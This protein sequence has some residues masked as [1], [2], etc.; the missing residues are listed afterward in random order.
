MDNVFDTKAKLIE[1]ATEMFAQNGYENTSM[2]E[3]AERA[4]ISKPAIYYYFKSKEELFLEMLKTTFQKFVKS[5]DEVFTSDLSPK[6]KLLNLIIAMFEKTKEKPEIFRIIH[7]IN[8]ED[9]KIDIALNFRERF[10]FIRDNLKKI[11][12]DGVKKGLFRNDIDMDVFLACFNGALSLHV[13][14]FIKV[15]NIELNR[16]RAEKI[17]DLFLNG[18]S[19]KYGGKE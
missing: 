8:L 14:R 16:E 6:E 4:G 9:I 2:R 3:I 12:D 17:L 11:F 1:I 13:L 5:I 18:I 19:K 7:S 10:K 15:G